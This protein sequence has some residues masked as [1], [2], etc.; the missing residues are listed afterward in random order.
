MVDQQQCRGDHDE[1]NARDALIS[2]HS[3]V[4]L[5]VTNLL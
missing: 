3:A 5:A 1:P 4:A 2:T